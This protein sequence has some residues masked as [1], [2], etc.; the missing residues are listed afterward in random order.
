MTLALENMKDTKN[1]QCLPSGLKQFFNLLY[2]M[3]LPTPPCSPPKKRKNIAQGEFKA[4]EGTMFSVTLQCVALER[5]SEWKRKKQM[6][7]RKA[8]TFE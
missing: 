1:L 6:G 4:Y 8:L 2:H 5:E 3:T 7:K